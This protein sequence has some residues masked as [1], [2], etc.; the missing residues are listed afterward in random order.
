MTEPKK[1]QGY[2]AITIG[3]LKDLSEKG[4]E[5]KG[6]LTKTIKDKME[7]KKFEG[8]HVIGVL[9]GDRKGKSFLLNKLNLNQPESNS[10]KLYAYYHSILNGGAPSEVFLKSPGKKIYEVD[11]KD[12]K[13]KTQKDIEE[14]NCE[15]SEAKKLVEEFII[16]NSSIIIYVM[17]SETLHDLRTINRIK[18]KLQQRPTTKLILVHNFPDFKRDDV[19]KFMNDNQYFNN[20]TNRQLMNFN[21]FKN[22]LENGEQKKD[23]IELYSLEKIVY[24]ESNSSTITHLFFGKDENSINQLNINFLFN[25]FGFSL[26]KEKF[27]LKE[28]FCKYLE[29]NYEKYFDC[30]DEKNTNKKISREGNNI[31]IDSNFKSHY[32]YETINEFKLDVIYPKYS[33]YY[34]TSEFILN[35]VSGFDSKVTQTNLQIELENYVLSVEGTKKID[36]DNLLERNIE[37]GDFF[38]NLYL[39]IKNGLFTNKK[40]EIFDKDGIITLKFKLLEL[41]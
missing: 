29:D 3:L 21:C 19:Y 20:D 14:I 30:T 22:T 35:I 15:D 34:T 24:N 39:P 5:Y 18:N 36:E 28:N 4:W 11:S 16:D 10:N 1:D 2:E 25:L 41:K 38:L 33:Y 27:N 17:G 12:S 9:G 8:F 6:E 37:H 13:D 23:Y 7:D 40:A 31:K 26:E 32:H